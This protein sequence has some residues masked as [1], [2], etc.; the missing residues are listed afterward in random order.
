MDWISLHGGIAN[1]YKFLDPDNDFLKYVS[2]D[3]SLTI[4]LL[5]RPAF[6]R[7]ELLFL[8]CRFKSLGEYNTTTD[9]CQVETV[10]DFDI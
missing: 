6:L 8:L 3:D 2:E 5:E 4:T 1:C 7:A 9:S 10:S